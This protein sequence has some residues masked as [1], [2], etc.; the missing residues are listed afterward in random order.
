MNEIIF[1]D[2]DTYSTPAPAPEPVKRGRPKGATKPKP[3]AKPRWKINTWE[4]ANLIEVL[5]DV[6]IILEPGTKGNMCAQL[7][8]VVE[9]L[10]LIENKKV[11]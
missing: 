9:L 7:K 6:A 3:A 1:V 4:A 11:S 2:E 10:E 8:V 5:R